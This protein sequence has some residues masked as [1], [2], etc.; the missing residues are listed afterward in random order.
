MFALISDRNMKT[1]DSIKIVIGIL[2]II[3][4]LLVV[5]LFKIES[6][7]SHALVIAAL[8]ACIC[9]LTFACCVLALIKEQTD[10]TEQSQSNTARPQPP[11][12]TARPQPPSNT[13]QPQP[14]SNTDQPQ[15]PSD[16]DQP[17]APS[18][19]DQPQ[20][21]TKTDQPQISS[22]ELTT[23]NQTIIAIS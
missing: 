23:N 6:E 12:N 5:S 20:P 9:L 8:V 3:I 11:S 13:A 18:T 22:I 7:I 14:P 19:T 10:D 2:V 15:A 21:S 16:T 1:S 17:Q 4:I